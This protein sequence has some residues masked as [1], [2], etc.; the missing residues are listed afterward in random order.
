LVPVRDLLSFAVFV[1]SFLGR[2]VNWRGHR[3]RLSTHKVA[4]VSRQ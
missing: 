4:G 3:Y 2:D 1:A